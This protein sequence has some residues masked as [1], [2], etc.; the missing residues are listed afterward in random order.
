[1]PRNKAIKKI[2]VIG[3]GPII[4]GQAAEF[5]YA[6]AQACSELKKIGIEIIL[7]NSNP[8]TIMTDQEFADKVYIEP[9]TISTLKKIIDIEKPDSIL[10]N[11]GGQI[12]LNLAIEL[13][14]S[15][16][17]TEKNVTLLG[18]NAESI[19]KAEDRQCFKDTMKKINQ[20]CIP[21]KVVKNFADALDFSKVIG[22]PVVVRPAFTLGGLGGGIANNVAELEDI[23]NLGI[24]YSR[25]GQILIEKCVS[26]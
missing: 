6:G 15:G 16:Y 9:L 26:G 2:L 8:A 24:G 5:D 4:I 22:F 11:V 1:M 19:K 7:V 13:F 23:A 25:T 20:P 3:S 14:E 12:G 17:L 10:P 18:T 21:S